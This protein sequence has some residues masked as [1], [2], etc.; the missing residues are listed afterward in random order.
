MTERIE[1]EKATRHV[2]NF[3]YVT[4]VESVIP[5]RTEVCNQFSFLRLA[6]LK[7]ILFGLIAQK[8]GGR[9]T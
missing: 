8:F 6:I 3:H 2:R 1:K 4:S 5:E 7:Q 9:Y